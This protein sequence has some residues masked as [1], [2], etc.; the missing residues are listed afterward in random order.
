MALGSAGL[1]LEDAMLHFLNLVIPN[2]FETSPHVINSVL[3]AIEG[4]RVALGPGTILQYTVQGL[5]HPARKVRDIYWRIYNSL[6]IS[7]QVKKRQW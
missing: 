7:S 3:E 1:G 6:Y 4:L 2:I 5:F